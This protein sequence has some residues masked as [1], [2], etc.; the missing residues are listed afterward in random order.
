MRY[1]RNFELI[2]VTVLLIL[3]PIPYALAWDINPT[4]TILEKMDKE[5]Y[6]SIHHFSYN[7]DRIAEYLINHYKTPVHEWI[8][9]MIYGCDIG[10]EYCSNPPQ[11]HKCAPEACDRRGSLER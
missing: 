11:P 10:F 3:T 5:F 4:A 8:T 9:H 1:Q 6:E 7:G 2:V